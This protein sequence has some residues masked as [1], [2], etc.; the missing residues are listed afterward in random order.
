MLVFVMQTMTPSSSSRFPRA[1]AALV[2]ALVA[3]VSFTFGMTLG[4]QEGAR[5]AVPP[6]EG[7]V[8]NQGDLPLSL[9]EDVDFRNFWDVWNFI[10]ESYY[11]Q[12]VSE[13]TLYYGALKGMVAAAGDPYT[14]YFDPTEAA[15]FNADLAGQFEGIGAE[16]GIKDDQLQVVAPLPGTPA[17]LAG[18]MPGDKILLIDGTDTTG[19]T[20]EAAV[21]LIRG[22]KGTQVVL[23]I[24]RNGLESAM[25]IPITRDTITVNSVAWTVEDNGIAV[26]SIYTFNDETNGLFNQAVN[27]VLA[28]NVRGIILDL[29]S[30]PGG[31]LTS[32]I[33][34]ASVWVGYQT[35]VLEKGQGVDQT[36][37]GPT[38]P[39]L[40]GMPTVV[41]VDGGTASGSEIV[42]GALQDYG[43]ATVVGTQTFGKGSVQ[44]YRDLPDGSAVKVTVAEWLTP[45]GRTI[46]ETGLTPDVIVEFT[47][48][49]FDA[50]RDPQKEKAV[51]ILLA[52]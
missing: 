38:A 32:A 6:G 44:D 34:V 45:L 22:P 23:T 40:E 37:A 13:K 2:L 47:Q 21:Q 41:L 8:L 7:H 42:A 31:L 19:M 17:E 15:E 43:L 39:R 14:M 49:D 3:V 9:Q 48:E 28:K 33:D 51:E 11:K 12:P 5:A 25:E 30:N 18:L 29:R 46:H 52:P 24:T 1:L 50:Q 20:V 35:V 27:D 16:I 10:K 4:R 36:F 26:I